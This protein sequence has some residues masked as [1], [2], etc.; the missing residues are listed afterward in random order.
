MPI[1]TWP[2]DK[3]IDVGDKQTAT[4]L[5]VEDDAD[6]C[7][8]VVETLESTGYHVLSARDGPEALAALEKAQGIDLMFSDLVMP[9]GMS[10]FELVGEARRLRPNLRILLTSGYA[11]QSARGAK[12]PLIK[13]PYR[14]ADLVRC[15]NEALGGGSA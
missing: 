14:L 4:I 2:I 1:T 15:I 10:G 9:H 11:A 13:K 8:A 3:R 7:M 12:F 6:V 5:V